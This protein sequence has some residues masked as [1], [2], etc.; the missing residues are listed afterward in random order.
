VKVLLREIQKSADGTE[1]RR[2]SV[3][4]GEQLSIGG[5]PGQAIQLLGI[6]ARFANLTLDQAGLKLKPL[7]GKA[8]AATIKT[9]ETLTIEGHRL[10]CFA[11][12]PGFNAAIE[13]RRNLDLPPSAF[14]KAFTTEL[15]QTRLSK[16]FAGWL[17][18]A[19]VVVVGLVLPLLLRKPMQPAAPGATEADIAAVETRASESI[20][21]FLF[22]DAFWTSGPL[23]SAHRAAALHN[24]SSCH[25]A[26]FGR[27]PDTACTQ[28]HK[29]MA[30]HVLPPRRTELGMA[31]PQRCASCHHEHDEPESHLVPVAD[32]MCA[33]CHG[34]N[35]PSIQKAGLKRTTDFSIEDHPKF[36]ARL[37]RPPDDT[38]PDWSFARVPLAGAQETSNLKFNHPK[39]LGGGSIV[40]LSDGK[41]LQCVDCHKASA[42]GQHFEVVTMA[43]N[44]SGCHSLGFDDIP[45]RQ[46]PHGKRYV[47]EVVPLLLDHYVRKAVDPSA[48]TPPR[49]KRRLPGMATEVEVNQV[50]TAAT[51]AC[52]TAQA[53][54]VIRQYFGEQN[55]GKCHV[56]STNKDAVLADRYVIAPVR[57]VY[58]YQPNSTFD[59]RQ[60]RQ[61]RDKSGDAACLS[62]HHVD[63][64]KADPATAGLLALSS[65]LNLPD[66][67]NCTECHGGRNAFRRLRSTCMGCHSY[68]PEAQQ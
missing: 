37:V 10:R 60:H 25:T 64:P 11:P 58:D 26:L 59:H 54:E 49:E 8:A 4:E 36:S 34:E 57:L 28:C 19:V 20:S 22:S 44:C 61:M 56:V 3:F 1:E 52:G 53:E 42:D 30:D 32:Q 33:S 45:P 14:E 24:C 66:I 13:I 68:H 67:D 46:L 12:P 31:E 2:D 40:R 5:A 41:P 15:S 18:A 27:V 16:R 29:D 9:G 17:L 21:P 63:K 7:D 6:P 55:C 47:Q 65:E 35:S 50:C 48:R 51:V 39:H 23:S 38:H 62:C 43:E